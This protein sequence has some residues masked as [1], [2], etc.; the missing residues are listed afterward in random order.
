MSSVAVLTQERFNEHRSGL[1]PE[2]SG[3]ESSQ[4]SV[5]LQHN[6]CQFTRLLIVVGFKFLLNR[7]RPPAFVLS[8]F[9]P[10]RGKGKKKPVCLKYGYQSFWN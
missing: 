4:V 8:Q 6:K 2:K 7:H 5:A 3:G 9:Q 10:K 1:Q